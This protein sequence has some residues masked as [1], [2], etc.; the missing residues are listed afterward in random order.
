MYLNGY[1]MLLFDLTPDRAA[2]EGHTSHPDNGN[3]RIELKFAEALPDA[4]TCLI[5][6]EYDGTV[7]IDDK[8][9]V[10]TDY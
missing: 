5:Y 1:F 3:V 2:S 7:L 8:Q 4:I 10:T 9:V 6:L